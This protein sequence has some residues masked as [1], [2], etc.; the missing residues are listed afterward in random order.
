MSKVIED[1]RE[2]ERVETMLNNAKALMQ[3]MEWTAE[4]AM[5]AMKIPDADRVKYMEKL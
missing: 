5:N 4:Q 3:S 1:M 2:K